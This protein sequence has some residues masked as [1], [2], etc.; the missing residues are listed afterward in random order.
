MKTVGRELAPS[1]WTVSAVQADKGAPGQPLNLANDVSAKVVMKTGPLRQVQVV[2]PGEEA[3]PGKTTGAQPGKREYLDGFAPSTQVAGSTFS[4]TVNACDDYWNI[5]N[6]STSVTVYRG[7]DP[8]YNSG[9]DPNTV[10]SSLTSGFINGTRI[11]EGKL[12]TATTEGWRLTT[13]T[14]GGE[15]TN[16]NYPGINHPEHKI[17]VNSAGAARLLVVVPGQQQKVGVAGGREGTVQPQRAGQP[18]NITVYITDTMWNIVPG[19]SCFLKAVTDDPYDKED[20]GGDFGSFSNGWATCLVEFH[21]GVGESYRIHLSTA[22]LGAPQYEPNDSDLITVTAGPAQQLIIKL[23]G[24]EF[25]QGYSTGTYPGKTDGSNPSSWVAG[26]DNYPVVRVV[27]EY[28]NLT[29]SDN[30]R[31]R[32]AS[33][34]TYYVRPDDQTTWNGE[35]VIRTQLMTAS[36]SGWTITVSTVQ[37]DYYREYTTRGSRCSRAFLPGWSCAPRERACCPARP[38][39]SRGRP[40]TSTRA[41]RSPWPCTPR[42]RRSTC[43]IPRRW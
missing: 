27:D 13:N 21:R 10:P 15:L 36:T 5:C 1:S 19:A 43:R 2:V 16:W 34:D 37:G 12:V 14:P 24:E 28:W 39:A 6:V 35:V 4:V 30:S 31:V 7:Y 22:G 17:K 42:T 26:V 29:S 32:L 38:P 8:V 11:F 3:V 40:R 41:S 33:D 20:Y 23:P 9:G 25:E 18:F